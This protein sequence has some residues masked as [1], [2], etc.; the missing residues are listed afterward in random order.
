MDVLTMT[1]YTS[2]EAFLEHWDG[3]RMVTLDLLT[4]FREADLSYR[5]VAD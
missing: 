3:V 2:L 1:T 5:L 4:S